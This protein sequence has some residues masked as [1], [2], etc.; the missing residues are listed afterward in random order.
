[1]LRTRYRRRVHTAREARAEKGAEGCDGE[2]SRAGV[3][4]CE[5]AG[6]AER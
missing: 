5:D 1:M 2:G 3:C 4:V 6:R